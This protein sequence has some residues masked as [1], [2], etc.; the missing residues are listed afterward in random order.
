MLLPVADTLPIT[1]WKEV[2]RFLLKGKQF[3]IL[4]LLL[5]EVGAKG[6][7]V[8]SLIGMYHDSEEKSPFFS[9][10]V[11]RHEIKSSE[12]GKFNPPLDFGPL[13]RVS[14]MHSF[15]FMQESRISSIRASD[16]GGG[17]KTVQMQA[18]WLSKKVL[19]TLIRPKTVRL[20]LSQNEMILRI[21]LI[22][23]SMLE[24]KLVSVLLMLKPRS[25]NSSDKMK[26]VLF[27]IKF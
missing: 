19:A 4:A 16:S 27:L 9:R 14:E 26:L 13:I 6:C 5:I 22:A 2:T 20:N 17:S 1:Q 23:E 3:R 7:G 25:L 11:L 24:F 8:D 12:D 21:L 10:P 18:I 15:F